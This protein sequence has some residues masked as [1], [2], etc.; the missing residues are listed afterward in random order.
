[1]P[2][3]RCTDI[4]ELLARYMEESGRSA[5]W[6]TVRD[7]REYF[8]LPETDGP[9]ISGFLKRINH[10]SFFSCRYKVARIEKLRDTV[11]PHRLIRKYLVQERPAQRSH[12]LPMPTDL[13]L[14]NR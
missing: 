13:S 10:G 7:I 4:P 12:H 6:I 3:S 1:M 9:A 5:L 8:Q 14:R 2:L 11:P